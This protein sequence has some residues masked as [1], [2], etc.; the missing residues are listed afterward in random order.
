MFTVYKIIID[1][2]PKN[3]ILTVPKLYFIIL[4]FK[5]V[6]ENVIK[7]HLLHCH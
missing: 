3:D 2:L 4:M 7:G 1:K 5:V 6:N